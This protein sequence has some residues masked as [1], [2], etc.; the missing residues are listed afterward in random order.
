MK[1]GFMLRLTDIQ[2]AKL[3]RAAQAKGV[4]M[5]VLLGQM[6]DELAEEEDNPEISQKVETGDLAEEIIAKGLQV[7]DLYQ[8]QGYLWE[9]NK[10]SN[11]MY[12]RAIRKTRCPDSPIILDTLSREGDKGKVITTM[13]FIYKYLYEQQIPFTLLASLDTRGLLLLDKVVSQKLR[14]ELVDLR[15][16]TDY[17]KR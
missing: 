2:K 9:V 6:I 17:L 1:Q 10:S 4:S 15:K 14:G 3:T 11:G 16:L 13:I 5:N 12:W 7:T 8:Y